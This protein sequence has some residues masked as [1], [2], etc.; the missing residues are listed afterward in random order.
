MPMSPAIWGSVIS[1]SKRALPFLMLALWPLLA[2]AECDFDD[3]PQMDGMRLATVAEAMQW[4]NMPMSVK[5]FST[6]AGL[7]AV[8]AFYQERWAGA[9]DLTTFGAWQ[10]VLHLNDDCMMMVQARTVGSQTS[11]RLMLVNPPEDEQVQRVLGSG[12]PV[13]PDAVVVTDMQSQDAQRDGQLVMLLHPDSMASAVSWYQAEM[14]RSGWQLSRRAF[15][16]NNATLIY[17]KGLKQLSV[18]FLRT[19]TENQTQILLNQVDR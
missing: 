19:T 17:S 5:G 6:D 1:M 12:V 18:V 8:L 16:Q 14:V 4:N 3:F 9:E 13:P 7:Q 11:G 2:R 10:Q 15:S